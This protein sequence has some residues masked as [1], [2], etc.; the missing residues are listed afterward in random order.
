[1][2]CRYLLA[3]PDIQMHDMAGNTKTLAEVTSKDIKN[4]LDKHYQ[5]KGMYIVLQTPD[6]IDK[7]MRYLEPT[8]KN[9]SQNKNNHP[10]DYRYD[11]LS[12]I[13]P[14]KNGFCVVRPCDPKMSKLTIMFEATIPYENKWACD[15]V[16]NVF[17]DG[18]LENGFKAALEQFDPRITV[19]VTN[20]SFI[21][22]N[23]IFNFSFN[24]N[25]YD[26][27]PDDI[28][29]LVKLVFSYLDYFANNEITADHIEDMMLKQEMD[30]ESMSSNSL[31]SLLKKMLL[32]PWSYF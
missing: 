22:G 27:N 18:T 24:F 7:V 31:F 26:I 13:M 30:Y 17:L 23:R 10:N 21:N 16:C 25:R 8:I 2:V 11:E 19:S 3:H 12:L 14:E 32:M 4:F 20:S 5:A 15:Y 28:E 29:K 9:Y 6:P 1:M